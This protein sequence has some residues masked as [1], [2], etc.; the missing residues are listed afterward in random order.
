MPDGRSTLELV[1]AR[2]ERLLKADEMT[3]IV[4]RKTPESQ[5]DWHL[6][7]LVLEGGKKRRPDGTYVTRDEMNGRSVKRD[8]FGRRRPVDDDPD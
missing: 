1:A 5:A 7:N 2:P 6:S 3:S 8:I 4:P